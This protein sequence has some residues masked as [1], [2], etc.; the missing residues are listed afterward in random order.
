MI[1]GVLCTLRV[2]D[3][4][5]SDERKI[6]QVV[7]Y[8]LEGQIVHA[9][10]DVVY[11]YRVLETPGP[12]GTAVLAVAARLDDVGGLL[13]EAGAQGVEPR[14][15]FAAPLVY[16]ALLADPGQPAADEVPIGCRVVLDIGHLRTNVCI[17]N[18]GEAVSART[19][20]RGGAALTQAIAQAYRCDEAM[21]ED[22]KLSRAVLASGSHPASNADELRIDAALKEALIPLLRDVRQ[23][24]ASVRGRLRAPIESV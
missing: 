14:S 19:I 12:E 8:E 11:D 20:L 18:G 9:L 5:F 4:P 15:L 22:V 2:L 7:G 3:L 24:L 23:T 21:A 13:A 16:Q 6:D 10:S 1:P 17:L